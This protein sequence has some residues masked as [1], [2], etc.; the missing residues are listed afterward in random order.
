MMKPPAKRLKEPGKPHKVVIN[1]IAHRLIAIA[2]AILKAKGT[3]RPQ[4]G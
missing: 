1:A 3:W 2:N 4:A